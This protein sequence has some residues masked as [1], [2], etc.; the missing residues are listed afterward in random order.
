MSKMLKITLMSMA[1]LLFLSGCFFEEKKS[2]APQMPPPNV[3]TVTANKG[4][5]DISFSYPAKAKSI[6]QIDLVAKVGGTLE[7]KLF[8]EGDMVKKGQI[9]YKIDPRTY[10]ATYNESVANLKSQ[11][12]SLQY[13]TSNWERTKNLYDVNAVSKQSYDD[14]MSTYESAI[15]AVESAKS[16]VEIAKINLDY[17]D[18]RAPFAG[19]TGMSKIDTGAYVNAVT[20]TLTQLTQVDPIYIEFSIPDREFLNYRNALQN[21]TVELIFASGEKNSQNGKI[22]FI[23][24]N[25]NTLTS[26]VQS[27]AIFEN[28]DSAIVPGQFVRVRVIGLK[29]LDKVSIPQE[30]VMQDSVSP[31]VY[32]FKDGKANRVNVKIDRTVGSDFV[33][34]SGL[35]GGEEIISDNL[36]KIR[37]N[38]PVNKQ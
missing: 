33:L 18:V 21:L 11:R 9:L 32:V 38:M 28:V 34:D 2:A 15:A 13:A 6:Q 7:K 4:D 37:P 12:A 25:I 30:V 17:T 31:Y 29:I 36:T 26:T 16:A 35:E 19:L 10:Q 8:K 24:S 22:D 14:A 5:I 23:D 3:K 27:R 1:M 20:D